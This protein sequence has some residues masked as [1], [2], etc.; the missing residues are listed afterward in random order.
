MPAW[1]TLS[2]SVLMVRPAPSTWG[3]VC[4]PLVHLPYGWAA[5]LL[6]PPS[7]ASPAPHPRASPSRGL[8]G[9]SAQPHTSRVKESIHLKVA[10]LFWDVFQLRHCFWLNLLSNVVVWAGQTAQQ[11]RTEWRGCS[12]SGHQLLDKRACRGLVLWQFW[13][14][15]LQPCVFRIYLHRFQS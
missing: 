1:Y 13:E 5:V 6:C 7:T 9:L 15:V 2:I 10:F 14:A 12:A 11:E 4:I 8:T 3:A